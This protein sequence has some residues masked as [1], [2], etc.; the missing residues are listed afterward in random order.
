M[1]EIVCQRLIH[2]VTRLPLIRQ[3]QR[4]QERRTDH[5]IWDFANFAG[6]TQRLE[7]FGVL[8]M[9]RLRLAADERF[10]CCNAR[11]TC[12][13]RRMRRWQRQHQRERQGSGDGGGMARQVLK[14][15]V[16]LRAD[17]AVPQPAD[18]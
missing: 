8:L 13:R 7:N 6:L 17:A 11:R 16:D 3:P 14:R 12:T 2:P 1:P 5:N 10:R 4:V 18:P 9:I 15:R